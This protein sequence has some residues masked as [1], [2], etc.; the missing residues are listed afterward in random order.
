MKRETFPEIGER[1]VDECLHWLPT[2]ARAAKNDWARDF[3]RSIRAQSRR[4]GWNPTPKQLALMRRL[5]SELFAQD[6]DLI[7]IED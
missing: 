6:D 3:A 7:L 5:V 2:I 1:S 4:K